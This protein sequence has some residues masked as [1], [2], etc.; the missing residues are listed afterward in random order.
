MR[1]YT[2]V[3]CLI[4]FNKTQILF[5]IMFIAFTLQHGDSCNT[6]ESDV[7]RRHILTYKDD[8]RSEKIEI[9]LMV[10]DP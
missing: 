10:V 1:Y 7:C 5:P 8:P 3:R 6:S 9:F 2:K 4:C